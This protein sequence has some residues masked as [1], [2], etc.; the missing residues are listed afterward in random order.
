MVGT[1]VSHYR[2]LQQLG[3]GG[4]GVVYLAEDERLHR[5]V[6]LKFLP[7]AVAADSHARAR[8]AREAQAAST[9]DHPNIATIYE[10]GDWD[11]QPF[12]AMAYYEGQ[13][14]KARLDAGPMAF[15]DVAA[16]VSDVAAGLSA[17]HGAG[18]V[19]RDL[20][21]ANIFLPVQGPAKILDFGLAK[22]VADDQ[23]T[24]TRMT[25]S[26]TTVGTVAY[27]APEQAQGQEVDQRAD[28]WALGVIL[29]EMLTGRLP[30]KADNAPATLLAITTRNPEA[31]KSLRP[32]VPPELEDVVGR[33]LQRNPAQRTTTA[34]DVLQAITAYRARPVLGNSRCGHAADMVGLHTET[35]GDSSGVPTRRDGRGRGMG[36]EPKREDTLG[37]R[38]R[39]SR[40]PSTARRGQ[41]AR[42]VRARDRGRA[43][44]AERSG[45]CPALAN[46]FAGRH[47]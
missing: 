4:M 17:A 14:L 1:N 47:D 36:V 16:I 37:A 42:C 29:Y 27:M 8:F 44:R 9:L 13:T 45:A 39:D 12:I 24:A 2:V 3:A 18:I 33:T 34:A 6:A 10:I 38:D 22:I 7:P 25:T 28:V 40:S 43:I 21:P 5:K 30:F 19:H 11:G 35:R 41:D 20:K 46:S 15:K 32:E 26:G 23:A 31:V